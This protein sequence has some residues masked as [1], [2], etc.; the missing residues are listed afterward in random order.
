MEMGNFEGGVNTGHPIPELLSD[1]FIKVSPI[2]P[3]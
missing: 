3:V 1:G 2:V